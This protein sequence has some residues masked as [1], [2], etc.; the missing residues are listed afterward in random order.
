MKSAV[1]FI[2]M[3]FALQACAQEKPVNISCVGNSITNG[4]DTFDSYRRELWKMLHDGKY[5]F[6]FVG[7]WNKHHMGGEVPHPDFDMDHEGHSGWTF[8][9]FFNPPDWDSARGNIYKWLRI[10]KPDIILLELGTNDVFQCRKTADMMV[11]LSKLVEVYRSVNLCVKIF[12]AQIPPLGPKWATQDLCKNGAYSIWVDALN[13]EIAAF[14]KKYATTISPVIVVDQFTGI[15]A[16]IHMYDDI[17]PNA[18][19]EKIMARR[20]FNAIEKYLPK[21]K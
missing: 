18:A 14:A 19:G 13:K 8:E 15:D 10:Y 5:N 11:D 6:D 7:S 3:A 21:L 17:H 9:H 1:V 12:V 4:T 16:S 20:W 2:I